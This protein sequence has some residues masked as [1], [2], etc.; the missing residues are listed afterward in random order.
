VSV[1][2]TLITGRC[3]ALVG[4]DEVIRLMRDAARSRM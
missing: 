3:K 2:S 1:V 4:T